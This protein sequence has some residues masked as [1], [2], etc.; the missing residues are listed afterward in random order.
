MRPSTYSRSA[1]GKLVRRY[2][3]TETSV[4]VPMALFY[5]TTLFHCGPSHPLHDLVDC[6]HNAILDRFIVGSGQAVINHAVVGL[7]TAFFEPAERRN[8]GHDVVLVSADDHSFPPEFPLDT[9][10]V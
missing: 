10:N 2:P 4:V 8:V 7:I 1:S 6:G 3:S 5:F 9:H